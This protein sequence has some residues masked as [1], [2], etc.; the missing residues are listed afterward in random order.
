[1]K[2]LVLEAVIGQKDQPR[3]GAKHRPNTPRE[4]C[5]IVEEM[6]EH[7][8]PY[9]SAT[10]APVEARVRRR[11]WILDT[12]S[13]TSNH[14][15]HRKGAASTEVVRRNGQRWQ[16]NCTHAQANAQALG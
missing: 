16:E 12:I 3:N 8:G 2:P 1:M 14:E 13:L 4:T 10:D 15:A 7:D 5:R 9:H 11:A 6:V